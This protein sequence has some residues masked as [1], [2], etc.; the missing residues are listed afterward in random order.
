MKS[1]KFQLHSAILLCLI[2]VLGKAVQVSFSGSA[3]A[4]Q[5]AEQI[6]SET[7]AFMQKKLL[8]SQ[9]ILKGLVMADFEAIE[10]ASEKIGLLSQHAQ[11]HIVRNDPVYNH[12]TIEFQRIAKQLSLNAKQKNLDGAAYA[13]DHLVATCI[14]CHKHI[15]DDD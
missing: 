7:D 1:H 4:G 8:L 10:Q 11:W 5:S 3:Q 6:I 12:F 9:E 15:R 13:N 14:A 2:L